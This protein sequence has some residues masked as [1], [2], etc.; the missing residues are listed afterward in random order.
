MPSSVHRPALCR[1]RLR[2]V[3]LPVALGCVTRVP[4]ATGPARA[5]ARPSA[6]LRS[7]PPVSV[8]VSSSDRLATEQALNVTVRVITTAHKR[9]LQLTDSVFAKD[10]ACSAG[11]AVAQWTRVLQAK[12]LV[13]V[14]EQVVHA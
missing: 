8:P 5:A 6:Q 10:S 2:C 3:T 14:A 9:I 13:P 12:L 7:S 11:G 1:A 4:P